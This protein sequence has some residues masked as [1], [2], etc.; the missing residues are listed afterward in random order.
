MAGAPRREAVCSTTG[1]EAPSL[2]VNVVAG[3][4]GPAALDAS[5]HALALGLVD[6]PRLVVVVHRCGRAGARAVSAGV[7][8]RS[9]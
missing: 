8:G 3:P 7:A 9:S 4:V 5:P 2:V 6:L 1:S